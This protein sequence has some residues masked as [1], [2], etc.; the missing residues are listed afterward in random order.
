[1]PS[2]RDKGALRAPTHGAAPRASERQ[3]KGGRLALAEAERGVERT[4][5]RLRVSGCQIDPGR[6][7]LLCFLDDVLDQCAADPSAPPLWSYDEV[8]EV[9]LRPRERSK[10]AEGD[11]ANHLLAVVGDIGGRVLDLNRSVS[12]EKSVQCLDAAAVA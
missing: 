6:A 11:H 1:M 10:H 4:P 12:R 3:A 9:R 5:S 7:R 8:V 2:L